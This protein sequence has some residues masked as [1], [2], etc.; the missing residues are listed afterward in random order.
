MRRAAQRQ[1]N[2]GRILQQRR[3]SRATKADQ[4]RDARLRAMKIIVDHGRRANER[5]EEWE[6][7]TSSIT[8]KYILNGARQQEGRSNETEEE[9]KIRLQQLRAR[10]QDS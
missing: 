3:E 9:S 10:Q 2:R 8:C 4:Q 5:A 1:Q 7:K 6:N